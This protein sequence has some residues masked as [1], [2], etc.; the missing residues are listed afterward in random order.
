MDPSR[1]RRRPDQVRAGADSCGAPSLPAPC[2]SHTR[3]A[4]LCVQFVVEKPGRGGRERLF[5]Q[6]GPVPSPS[7]DGVLRAPR[8]DGG[9][10]TAGCA[11]HPFPK[12]KRS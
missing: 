4:R 9:A 8:G 2:L 1:E 6:E 3:R 12:Y 7:A 10:W 11:L 5:S